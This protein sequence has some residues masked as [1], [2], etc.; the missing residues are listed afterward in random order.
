MDVSKEI[1]TNEWIDDFYICYVEEKY[2][3]KLKEIISYSFI[4]IPSHGVSRVR[5]ASLGAE[6]REMRLE[7][8]M[9]ET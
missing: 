2:S 3:L 8:L 7:I 5:I 6:A 1:S 4:L 9:H